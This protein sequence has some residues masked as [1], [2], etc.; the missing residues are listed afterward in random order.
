MDRKDRRIVKH[1]KLMMIVISI[2]IVLIIGMLV[3]LLREIE[4]NPTQVE[5]FDNTQST[6]LFQIEKEI[7]PVTVRNNFYVVKT[8]IEK[9]YYSY[10]NAFQ[11]L[12]SNFMLE[13]EA[14]E[15]AKA[16]QK[17][18]RTSIYKM[19]DKEYIQ[20][21]GLTI[22]N[23]AEKL[24]KKDE[25]SVQITNMYVSEQT[26][27]IAVYF[28]YG[29]LLERRTGKNE[30]FAMMVKVDM[31]KETFKILLQD[32]MQ[33]KYS[34]ITVGSTVTFPKEEQILDEEENRFEYKVVLDE[35]YV[36]DLFNHYKENILY[37]KQKAYQLLNSEYATKRFKTM[38]N[39]EQYVQEN[40]SKIAIIKI[41]QY[42]KEDKGTYT[43]YVCLDQNGNNYIFW[44][45]APMQYQVMLDTYTIE[46]PEFKAKYENETDE[47]K[48]LMNIQKF[49]EAINLADYEYAYSKLDNTYKVNNFATLQDFTNYVKKTFYSQNKL[50]AGK[51]QKQADLY[52]YDITIENAKE[53]SA[54]TITKRFVMQ[55]KEANDFVMSFEV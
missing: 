35:Q 17:A 15:F 48:V 19:L 52:L 20:Y 37:D 30:E 4:K 18:S 29:N 36:V 6:G 55:L 49:F 11:E 5:E 13:G 34:N 14:L 33:E 10:T 50:S 27:N 40:I 51:A 2:I 1:L 53:G 47:K 25:I 7:Q 42:Q 28:V 21:A 38:Q 41:E 24:P 45:T 43:Q 16:E 22:E 46:L 31:L 3:F 8:C 12:Q 32:Y 26:E 9:F 44:E 54:R 39:F 23:I